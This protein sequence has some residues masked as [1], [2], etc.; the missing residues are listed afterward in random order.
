VKKID[1][2]HSHT[3]LNNKRFFI[4]KIGSLR[5]GTEIFCVC[6]L[7]RLLLPLLDPS[8]PCPSCKSSASK[9]IWRRS[10]TWFRSKGLFTSRLSSTGWLSGNTLVC[11]KRSRTFCHF[12]PSICWYVFFDFT[13]FFN[14]WHFSFKGNI[15]HKSMQMFSFI[16]DIC[17]KNNDFRAKIWKW[18]KM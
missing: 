4:W 1:C 15:Y 9:G 5:E 6:T 13:Y 3:I 2:S 14:S 7:L 16:K 12:L 11:C 17:K 10:T 8:L 18:D